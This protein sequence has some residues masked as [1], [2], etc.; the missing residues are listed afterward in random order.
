MTVPRSSCGAPQTGNYYTTNGGP[1]SGKMPPLG[2]WESSGYPNG[3]DA[4]II[5]NQAADIYV[6]G[7]VGAYTAPWTHWYLEY[8]LGR[9][10]ELGFAVDAIRAHTARFVID[11]I[12]LSGYPQLL[13]HYELP[14]E[15]NCT[16]TAAAP[17]CTAPPG[18]FYPTWAA[19]VAALTPA[20]VT[21]ANWPATGN[22][23]VG[24]LAAVFRARTDADRARR[25]LP[26]LG[27]GGAGDGGRPRR[28]RGDP[29][30]ALV[31][32]Q[33]LPGDPAGRA[34]GRPQMGDRAAHR[35]QRAAAPAHRHPLRR[36]RH[37]SPP[38]QSCGNTRRQPELRQPG[39]ES[40]A[41][42]T[43][44]SRSPSP[45]SRAVPAPTT[46]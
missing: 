9:V 45:P 42:S 18:G 41:P 14:T 46:P 37:L 2:N 22:S 38:A 40:A 26:V 12:N 3:Q 5:L 30:V 39:S 31:S 6:P 15:A 32:A 1:V 11:M 8:A 21:G 28:R 10:A 17:G 34:S 33:R 16:N 4:S 29:G 20:Y 43:A 44:R 19:T 27:D 35:Y 7:A 24:D 36:R 23:G 25:R 13:A